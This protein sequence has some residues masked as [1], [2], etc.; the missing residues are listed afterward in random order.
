MTSTTTTTDDCTILYNALGADRASFM[1]FNL[2]DNCCAAGRNRCDANQM[3]TTLDLTG[4]G[5][6][7]LI[8]SGLS[9]LRNLRHIWA[10]NNNFTGNIP[11]ALADMKSLEYVYFENCSLSGAVSSKF[12]DV[13]LSSKL[14]EIILKMEIS[15]LDLSQ[16]PKR[17]QKISHCTLKLTIHVPQQISRKRHLPPTLNR[18]QPAA[19]R[20]G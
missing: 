12:D 16:D 10:N 6:S 15:V 18:L 4:H 1:G 14:R 19:L 9:N 20:R 5:L 13:L 7:G 2:G 3:I 8:P 11:I 17:M